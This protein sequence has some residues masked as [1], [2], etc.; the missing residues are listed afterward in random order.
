[1]IEGVEHFNRVKNLYIYIYAEW[2]V[3]LDDCYWHLLF[4]VE[5]SIYLYEMIRGSKEI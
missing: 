5:M 3:R 2:F 1:M 4:L